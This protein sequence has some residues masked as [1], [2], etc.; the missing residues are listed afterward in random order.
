VIVA[1]MNNCQPESTAQVVVS[2]AHKAKGR[3]WDSVRLAGDFD[4][5]PRKNAKG[6]WT[7]PADGELRLAYV[8]ATRAKLELDAAGLYEPAMTT[9]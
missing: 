8:A 1:I 4:V 9:V 2:T 5:Q 7:E 6:D 3:E